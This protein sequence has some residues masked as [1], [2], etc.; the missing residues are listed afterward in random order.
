MRPLQNCYEGGGAALHPCLLGDFSLGFL[1]TCC[2]LACFCGSMLFL[3]MLGTDGLSGAR[4]L[5]A[6][7]RRRGHVYKRE[8]G[9]SLL[10]FSFHPFQLSRCAERRER[11]KRHESVRRKG[12]ETV[13]GELLRGRV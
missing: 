1:S 12:G 6:K 9:D 2:S 4:R 3:T 10:D 7:R 8:G 11:E 5:E 13:G